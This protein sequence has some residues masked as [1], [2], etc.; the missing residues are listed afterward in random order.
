MRP[1]VMLETLRGQRR[2]LSGWSIGLTCLVG[3]YAGIYPSMRGTA[4]YTDIIDRMPDTVR[5][6]FTAG[7]GGDVTSG[8]GYLY[9]ELLSFMAPLLVL[10]YAISSGASA[11]AGEEDRHTLDLLLANPISRRR[12]VVERFAALSA[13]LLGLCA[14]LTVAVIALGAAAGMGL[15]TVNVLATMLNLAMLGAVFGALALAIGCRTGLVGVSR[16]AAALCAVLAYLVSGL[17]VT[18]FW[19]RQVRPASPFYQ[20]L[21]HDPIRHGARLIDIAVP[22]LTITVLVLIAIALVEHREL[23]G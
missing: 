18:V 23:R 5:A 11:V 17:G 8:P 16:A 7:G 2:V 3:M 15:S 6:L 19:L 4:S 21:G 14:T 9:V 12:L 1:T 10:L 13:G 20:Y 22:L